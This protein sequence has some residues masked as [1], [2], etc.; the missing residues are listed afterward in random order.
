LRLAREHFTL[1][2][3]PPARFGPLLRRDWSAPRLPAGQPTVLD[4]ERLCHGQAVPPERLGPAW[5]LVETWLD[6]LAPALSLELTSDA[7]DCVD[8]DVRRL[9]LDPGVTLRGLLRH[10]LDLP[11]PPP[12]G[13]RVS[14]V[15]PAQAAAAHRAWT[16]HAADF[17]P[18]AAD[19]LAPVR[20]FLDAEADWRRTG[21]VASWANE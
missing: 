20:R 15:T 17:T 9:G 16:D 7:L 5:R 1:P 19:T 3:P 4:A 10:R 18:S 12:P 6:D 11:L 14:H 13:R 8:A 21:L 2:P